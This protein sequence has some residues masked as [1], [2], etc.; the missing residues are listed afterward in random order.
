MQR[1]DVCNGDADGLCA[2]VQWRWF[3]PAQATLI[4]G[5]KREIELLRRVKAEAGDEVNVFDLSMQRN[6]QAMRA[7]LDAGVR[8]RYVDHHA[9]GQIPLHPLLQAHVDVGRD[10]CTSLLVDRLIQ[11]ACRAWALVGAYGDN[12]SAVADALAKS[13][14][15]DEAARAALKRMGEA[16]NYNAYGDAEEDVFLAPHRLYQIMRRYRDPL[17]LLA[18]EAI[19]DELDAQRLAD[20]HQAQSLSPVWQGAAGQMLLLPDAS[21]ARRVMGVLANELANAQPDQAHAVLR[22]QP[23][24]S[25][26]VSVRAPL[27]Q[28]SGA[29]A[30][31]HAFGGNGRARAAGIDALPSDLLPRFIEAFA[32]AH[33][34]A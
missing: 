24:G 19:I 21:W 25:Y 12:L 16:L 3:E 10:V 18:S 5:L 32:A 15:F 30:L 27:R 20:L 2:A 8:V 34:G 4:T 28:P 33:W 9:S 29:Q 23:D 14:G 22:Q 31:C 1:F 11:G 7:L 26:T 13:S 17:A 6:Q